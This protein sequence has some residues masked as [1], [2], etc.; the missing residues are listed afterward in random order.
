MQRVFSNFTT[1]FLSTAPRL[2]AAPLRHP[3]FS[4]HPKFFSRHPGAAAPRL[5]S[6][7]LRFATIEQNS[8]RFKLGLP[9]AVPQA[10]RE[11]RELFWSSQREAQS[12]CP[13]EFGKPSVNLVVLG[14]PDGM[15]V[16]HPGFSGKPNAAATWRHDTFPVI[17]FVL[18]DLV[19]DSE[20]SEWW[21]ATSLPSLYRRE[22]WIEMDMATSQSANKCWLSAPSLSGFHVPKQKRHYDSGGSGVLH[23]EVKTMKGTSA[24]LFCC[25]L[26][27]YMAVLSQVTDVRCPQRFRNLGGR[28]NPLP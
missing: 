27:G 6:T 5:N 24:V 19:I 10:S 15:P 1:S 12:D 20:N 25:L 26:L 7:A 2:L 17:A 8:S 22:R 13:S 23:E 16:G 11:S 18:D 4:R 3:S 9:T 21:S 28:G 14:K